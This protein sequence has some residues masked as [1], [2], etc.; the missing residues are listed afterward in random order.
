MKKFFLGQIIIALYCFPVYAQKTPNPKFVGVFRDCF[1]HCATYSLNPD[2]TFEYRSFG[3]SHFGTWKYVG[4]NKIKLYAPGKKA[5]RALLTGKNN[6][7]ETVEF[8]LRIP[9]IQAF[10]KVLFFENDSICALFNK[11]KS[12]SCYHRIEREQ[13]S[14]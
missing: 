6:N 9:K 13:L 3:M 10:K 5:E 2:F 12:K 7:G 14:N 8:E 4:E 1:I 11:G